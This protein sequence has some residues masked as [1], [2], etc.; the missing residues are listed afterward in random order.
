VWGLGAL[1]WAYAVR[2]VAPLVLGIGLIAFW[3][4][5]EVMSAGESAFAVSTALAGV[6]PV[7][8]KVAQPA[9][10]NTA[11]INTPSTVHWILDRSWNLIPLIF[12][13]PSS[14]LICRIFFCSPSFSLAFSGSLSFSFSRWVMDF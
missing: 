2:G 7:P 10:I 5:W 8:D 1:L 14:Y 11:S 9:G 13:S 4:V 6:S 3:F 12:P